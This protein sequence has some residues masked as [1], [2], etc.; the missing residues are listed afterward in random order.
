MPGRKRI[1]DKLRK[2]GGYA[3]HSRPPNKNEPK[4]ESVELKPPAHI[5]GVA[6]TYWL[7]IVPV[8]ANSG[9]LTILDYGVVEIHCTAYEKFRI[10]VKNNDQRGI[11]TW[12]GILKWTSASLG[13]TPP[14]RAKLSVEPKPK[15]ND[16]EK[17]MNKGKNKK[18][19]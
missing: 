13:L 18:N 16:F 14:D 6:R 17:F 12:A 9:I 7:K 2:A 5:K 3:G 15:E 1:P 11:N 19:G 8:L 10:A 4:L